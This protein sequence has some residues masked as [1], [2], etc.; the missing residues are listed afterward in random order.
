MSYKVN[1]S[2]NDFP[3][4]LNKISRKREKNGTFIWLVTI[5][6]ACC[7]CEIRFFCVC[8]LDVCLNVI[9]LCFFVLLFQSGWSIPVELVVGPEQKGIAYMTDAAITVRKERLLLPI[10]NKVTFK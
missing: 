9:N 8:Q 3:H 7:I 10:K 5:L 1:R 4:M 6:N 2:L